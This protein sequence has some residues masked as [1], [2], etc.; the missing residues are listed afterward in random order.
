MNWKA[1]A[2]SQKLI[3][4]NLSP[5]PKTE[6]VLIPDGRKDVP[7]G[8]AGWQAQDD[9]VE[10]TLAIT[11]YFLRR[12]IALKILPDAPRK[13]VLTSISAFPRLYKIM[14]RNFFSGETG[15][16]DALDYHVRSEGIGRYILLT[17]E[18]NESLIRKISLLISRG[19]KV[20]LIYIGDSSEV[21]SLAASEKKLSFVQAPSD[22]DFFSVLSGGN[23]AVSSS[24][25]GGSQ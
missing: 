4:K 16:E 11:D 24:G 15:V 21:A 1:S 23:D 2:R 20:T 10:G 12:G 8:E 7:G 14:A 22:R 25:K 9:V 3:L 17:W 6:L 19:A 5:E 18:V 13:Q